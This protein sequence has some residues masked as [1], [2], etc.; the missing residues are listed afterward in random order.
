MYSY[1][2]E[3]KRHNLCCEYYLKDDITT[4]TTATIPE[5]GI[6]GIF[7]FL[8]NMLMPVFKKAAPVI[9]TYVKSAPV[10]HGLK[11]MR[12]KAIQ[13]AV[14]TASDVI[15]GRDPKE[16]LKKDMIKIANITSDTVL[17]NNDDGKVKK[18]LKGKKRK[19]IYENLGRGPIK[20]F[21]KNISVFD[22]K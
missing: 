20:K 7:R 4:S 22:I 9:K 14:N 15:A 11:K 13:S 8:S 3:V 18:K 12:K 19:N 10:Q 17:G 5:D 21:K 2:N 1:S 16:R 6:G